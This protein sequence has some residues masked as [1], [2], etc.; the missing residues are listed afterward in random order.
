MLTVGVYPVEQCLLSVCIQLRQDKK[1]SVKSRDL[2][3]LHVLVTHV[4]SHASAILKRSTT[5]IYA[6]VPVFVT[7]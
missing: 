3:V 1:Q 2:V 6:A 5:T 4:E 7:C